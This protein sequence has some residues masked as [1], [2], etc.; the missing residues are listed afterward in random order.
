MEPIRVHLDECPHC[1]GEYQSLLDT[2]RLLS[3][4]ANR[5]SRAEIESLLKMEEDRNLSESASMGVFRG[6]LRPKPLTATALLSLAGLWIASA[7]LDRPTD[8][9]SPGYGGISSSLSVATMPGFDMGMRSLRHWTERA[10]SGITSA[11]IMSANQDGLVVP[12]EIPYPVGASG[13]G[14]YHRHGVSL[15]TFVSAAADYSRRAQP[16]DEASYAA[17]GSYRAENANM[18]TYSPS[19]QRIGFGGA[20][21]VR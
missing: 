9:V 15:S 12:A 1:R 11:P 18:A 6:V 3:S 19:F 21:R 8:G 14:Y 4:L 5:T 17:S 2:K 10:H 20:D 13:S 7:S 16:A